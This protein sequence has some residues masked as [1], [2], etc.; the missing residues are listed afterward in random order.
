MENDI[1]NVQDFGMIQ[2]FIEEV[3]NSMNNIERKI[4]SCEFYLIKL[5]ENYKDD[6]KKNEC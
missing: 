6:N 1:K 2:T 3:Q 4:N 5:V